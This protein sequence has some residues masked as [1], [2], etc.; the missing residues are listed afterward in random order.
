MSSSSRSGSAPRSCRPRFRRRS[1]CRPG[2]RRRP[3]A[4]SSCS[5]SAASGSSSAIRTLQRPAQPSADPPAGSASTLDSRRPASGQIGSLRGVP[6]RASSRWQTLARPTPVPSWRCAPAARPC[7]HASAAV[8]DLDREAPGSGFGAR[9]SAESTV[10]RL[11]DTPYLIAFST[12]G[13]RISAG[14]RACSSSSG[15]SISTFSR[16]RKARLLDVE[17]EPLQVDLLG[18]ADV[19]ARDRATGWCGRRSTARGAW[20]RLGRRG[21]P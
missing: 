1:R 18:Q 2:R 12:I 14:R 17:I 3:C 19:G 9:R 21:R 8:A 13:W 10:S 15:M 16:S 20:S 5:R 11:F 6:K 7:R 4:S